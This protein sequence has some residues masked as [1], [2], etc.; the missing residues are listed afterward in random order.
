MSKSLGNVVEPLELKN[1]YGLDAFRFFLMRDMAFGLDSNFSETALI[2]R[3]NSDLAND[4]GNLFS[5]VLTMVHKY[6]AGRVPE[7]DP[8]IEE[9]F[10]LGLKIHAVECIAEYETH[11]TGFAFHRAL[12]SVWELINHLNKYVDLTAPWVLA[13]KKSTRKQLEVVIYNLL[14][15]L[16]IISGLIFPVMPGTAENMQRHLG[17]DPEEP[18]Y[19]LETLKALKTLPPGTRIRKSVSLFPRI[20][21]KTSNN[22]TG[23]AETDLDDGS[24]LPNIKPMITIEDFGKLDLRVATVIG[25]ETIP[26][27]KKLLK[28]DVDMGEKRTIVAGIAETYAPEALIGKQIVIVANLKPAKLM[29][30]LSNGMM[31]A[32]VD[33]KRLSVV[34]LDDTVTPGTPLT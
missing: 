30:I 19:R 21:I 7:T 18:F 3:I 32:A 16:R 4:L 12:M 2:Q 28:L 22:E 9:E 10:R 14:E 23:V 11:M 25:A 27:A 8:T 6:F 5:R 15:G 34:T 31:L 20:D 26:R 33:K 13:K 1:I 17:L 29:G 24:A